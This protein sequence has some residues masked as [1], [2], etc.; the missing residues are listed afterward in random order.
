MKRLLLVVGMFAAGCFSTSARS[1]T[2]LKTPQPIAASADQATVVFVRPSK[3]AWAISANIL[4]E[5]G[6][7]LGDMPADGHFAVTLP[8]GHHTFVVWAENTDAL[9]ADLQPGKVYY[10]EVYASMGAWSAHMHFRA[11]KPSLPS[12]AERDQWMTK[13]KQY[14]SDFVTGQ[15]NLDK[16]G[17]QA[18]NERLR[19]GQ[20]HLTQ[21]KGADLDQHTLAA[22]DGI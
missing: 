4:D 12:W 21:Y 3:L 10:V 20:E 7:F 15:A 19:R 11:I 16:K 13:T 22:A 14:A 2:E 8:P 18:V 6:K 9:S 1:M 17:A 5:N